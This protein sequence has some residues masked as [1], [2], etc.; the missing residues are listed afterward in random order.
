MILNF[1]QYFPTRRL[2]GNA[3]IATG[4]ADL[5]LL[6]HQLQ[7]TDCLGNVQFDMSL[8][9]GLDYYTGLIYEAVLK[10][11]PAEAATPTKQKKKANQEEDE[12][13][14]ISHT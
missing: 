7:L 14:A 2:Q 5:Q 9:R 10:E 12:Q 1:E 4:I 8:A 3:N 13:V 11:A 6:L